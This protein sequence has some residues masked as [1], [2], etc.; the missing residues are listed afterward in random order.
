[1]QTHTQTLTRKHSQSVS[2][3][4]PAVLY[5]GYSPLLPEGQGQIDIILQERLHQRNSR[6]YIITSRMYVIS[7]QNVL[8][9]V[10]LSGGICCFEHCLKWLRETHYTPSHCYNELL[11]LLAETLQSRCLICSVFFWVIESCAIEMLHSIVQSSHFYHS[12]MA[13]HK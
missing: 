2:A 3:M 9:I 10:S 7:F 4:S 8:Y 13:G 12:I 6:M 5:P 11:F 1:M